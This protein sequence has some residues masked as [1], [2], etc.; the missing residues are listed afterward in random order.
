MNNKHQIRHL[1]RVDELTRQNKADGASEHRHHALANK[2]LKRL[3]EKELGKCLQ[4][5]KEFACWQVDAKNKAEQH[6]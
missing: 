4:A 2:T 3:S 6:L 1:K 5:A